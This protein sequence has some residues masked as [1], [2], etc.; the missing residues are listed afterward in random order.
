MATVKEIAKDALGVFIAADGAIILTGQVL[1]HPDMAKA[2]WGTLATPLADAVTGHAGSIF[3]DVPKGL[4]N[5]HTAI[6]DNKSGSLIGL[7]DAFT[8][9]VAAGLIVAGVL[10]FKL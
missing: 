6:V 7:N 3:S 10:V 1:E 8:E 9:V 5:I 2:L 4:D